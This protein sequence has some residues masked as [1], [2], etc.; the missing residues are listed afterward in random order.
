MEIISLIWLGLKSIFWIALIIT[1]IIEFI[2]MIG[3]SLDDNRAPGDSVK[4]FLIMF[5]VFIVL[6]IAGLIFWLLLYHFESPI[7]GIGMG[8]I[9]GIILRLAPGLYDPG[10]SPSGTHIWIREDMYGRK[11][12]AGPASEKAVYDH[13]NGPWSWEESVNKTRLFIR[14]L[15]YVI[16]FIVLW[17]MFRDIELLTGLMFGYVSLHLL[18]S[19]FFATISQEEKYENIVSTM[20]IFLIIIYLISIVRMTLFVIR[21]I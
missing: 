6:M 14:Y 11:S 3:I 20:A 17:N 21:S 9:F 2:L 18:L 15:G 19:K 16:S 12:V 10:H 4:G 8:L 13:Y 5:P 1:L 7:V